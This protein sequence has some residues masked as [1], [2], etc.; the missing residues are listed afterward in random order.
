S[1][2]DIYICYK[3][4]SHILL[5]ISKCF[6]TRI[7]SLVLPVSTD[8]ALGLCKL[9]FLLLYGNNPDSPCFLPRAE[10]GHCSNTQQK[11]TAEAQL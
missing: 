1:F 5:S 7:T 9:E 8:L 3:R 11:R 4:V 6:K 10:A 2:K